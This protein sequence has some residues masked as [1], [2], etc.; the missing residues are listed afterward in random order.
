[1]IWILGSS[2]ITVASLIIFL[3]TDKWTD[4]HCFHKNFNFV[5]G[6]SSVASCI[7]VISGVIFAIAMIMLAINRMGIDYEVYSVRTRHD[8]LVREYEMLNSDCEDISKIEVID[9]ITKWNQSVMWERYWAENPWTNWFHP[10]KVTEAYE[11]IE[12]DE[13]DGNK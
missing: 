6:L 7:S 1:M 13:I 10:K 5:F 11:Y 4:K 8:A 12:L 9:K 2:L 3:I